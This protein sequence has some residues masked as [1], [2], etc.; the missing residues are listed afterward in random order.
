MKYIIMKCVIRFFLLLCIV[1]FSAHSTS[2]EKK[3]V[4]PDPLSWDA[5]DGEEDGLKTGVLD[6][7]ECK[8]DRHYMTC[9]TEHEC[10]EVNLLQMHYINYMFYDGQKM[11]TFFRTNTFWKQRCPVKNLLKGRQCHSF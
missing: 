11:V 1:L 5:T 4:L 3:E 7:L 2:S 6:N 8:E 10:W 9:K